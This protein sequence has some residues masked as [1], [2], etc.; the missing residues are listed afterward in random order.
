VE[1]GEWR[2]ESGKTGRVKKVRTLT[3]FFHAKFAKVYAKIAKFYS[4]KPEVFFV[5]IAV[6]L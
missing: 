6:K 1:S 2:V 3:V 4:K 5:S